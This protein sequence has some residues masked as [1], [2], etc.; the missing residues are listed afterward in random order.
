[1]NN[2]EKSVLLFLCLTF[3]VGVIISVFRNHREKSKLQ[4]IVIH[5]KY[6][7]TDTICQKIDSILK[8]NINTATKKEL[9]ALPGI[10]PTIAQRIIDYRQNNGKFKTKEELLNVSGIG[11]KKFK[12]L[13]NM[14]T[15]K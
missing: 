9:E 8:I 6:S 12:A 15:T 2:K 13:K 1:M 3:L 4:Q 14:I 11:P 7:F 5:Q 10:G